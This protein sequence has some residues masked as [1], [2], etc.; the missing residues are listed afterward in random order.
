ML[1]TPPTLTLRR[2]GGGDSIFGL[3][4]GA[5]LD[6]FFTLPLEGGGRGGGDL[7]IRQRFI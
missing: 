5:A 1:A 7:S 3:P 2:K 6:S 4:L